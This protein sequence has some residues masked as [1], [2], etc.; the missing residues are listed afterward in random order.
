M[1]KNND[2]RRTPQP[3]MRFLA[4][5][6]FQVWRT[7]FPYI[8]QGFKTEYR[9]Y[10]NP[11]TRQMEMPW[12]LPALAYS[13]NHANQIQKTLLV[14]EAVWR[15]RLGAISEESLTGEGYESVDAFKHYWMLRTGKRPNIMAYINVRRFR[16]FVAGD[17]HHLGSR[18]LQLLY[19]EAFDEAIE[20][21]DS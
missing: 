16:P 18:L 14:V 21:T 11:M 8:A 17:S 4:T 5:Q 3:P 9:T 7:D 6:R 12:P 20:T 1:P 10:G 15:E 2:K 13:L 19:G